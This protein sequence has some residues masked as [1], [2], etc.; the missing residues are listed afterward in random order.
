MLFNDSSRSY[1][2]LRL[3]RKFHLPFETP[4]HD[5]PVEKVVLNG[6]YHVLDV[7]GTEFFG[8]EVFEGLE[9]IGFVHLFLRRLFF[10]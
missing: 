9:P 6:I 1:L 8:V 5:V 2:D 4:L 3:V 10:L 7:S